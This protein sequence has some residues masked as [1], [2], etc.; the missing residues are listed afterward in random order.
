MLAAIA[1]FLCFQALGIL[2]VRWLLPGRRPLDR[3]WLGMSLGLLEEMWFPALFAF[4]WQFDKEAHWAALG[5]GLLTAGIC[6]VGREEGPAK[7][8]DK[9]ETGMLR[10]MLLFVLPLTV[11]AI[12]ILLNHRGA[13]GGY[14]AG[15]MMNAALTLALFFSLAVAF[16]GARAL[17]TF[18]A[19]DTSCSQKST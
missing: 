14:R 6:H 5:L 7:P 11:A 8:W 2:S 16:S 1:Y 15:W 17:G 12:M 13:M 19:K 4:L 3:I 18:C 10:R 9:A